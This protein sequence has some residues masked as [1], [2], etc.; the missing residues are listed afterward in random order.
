MAD[1]GEPRSGFYADAESGVCYRNLDFM[2]FPGYRVGDDG[3][4]WSRWHMAGCGRARG[5]RRTIASE[6]RQLRATRMYAQ[7]TRRCCAMG[8]SLSNKDGKIRTTL[9]H[10]LVLNAFVGP[11]PHGLLCRHMDGNPPNNNVSNL[12]WGT[13]TENQRDRIRHGTNL[14][15][16]QNPAAKIT[17]EEV[18]AIRAEHAAGG[19]TY[20]AI[21][22]KRNLLAE[23]VSSIVRRK[24]WKHVV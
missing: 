24:T 7:G 14:P 1:C 3:S 9:V 5:K 2:G 11:R 8:V 23:N 10:S 4:V 13:P 22:A 19:V 6:W 15:G 12:R 18:R 16:E 20:A 21:A 17:E